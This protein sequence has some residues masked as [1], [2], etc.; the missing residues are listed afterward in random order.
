M[1]AAVKGLALLHLA[2]SYSGL[3]VVPIAIVL[4]AFFI[5]AIFLVSQQIKQRRCPHLNVR[6][7][8]QIRHHQFYFAEVCMDCGKGT[9]P[10]RFP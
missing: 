3:M 7:R 10:P 9:K 4:L 6:M 2:G 8:R 5:M 1:I